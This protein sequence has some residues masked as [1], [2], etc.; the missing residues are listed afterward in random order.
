M[1]NITFNLV[2]NQE[3]HMLSKSF[4]AFNRA[5]FRQNAI[6]P[7]AAAPAKT[8]GKEKDMTKEPR[9]LEN[10]QMFFNRA[11][12]T[13]GIPADWL[14][15]IRSCDSII[16]FTFPIRRDNGLI[17]TVTAYRAQH[18]HHFLPVKGG[19]RYAA[20][21]DLQ[22]TMALAT[23]MTYKLV[24]LMFLSEELKVECALTPSSTPKTNSKRSL[25]VTPWSS[26]K[27]ALLDPAL[28]ASDPTWE[29]TSRS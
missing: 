15:L 23:L 13:T 16:R 1:G 27:R 6:R 4:A 25:V 29:P 8:F 26:P 10:V 28:I 21:I 7:F 3:F 12:A 9:F 18:K 24:S 20:G 17:E 22:E 11:A 19:T 5:A 2:R 14:E